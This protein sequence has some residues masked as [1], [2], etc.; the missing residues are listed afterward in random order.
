MALE[1]RRQPRGHP[2]LD[3][4]RLREGIRRTL[5][6]IRDGAPYHPALLPPFVAARRA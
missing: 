2:W 3:L 1:P 6:A 4:D 5:A